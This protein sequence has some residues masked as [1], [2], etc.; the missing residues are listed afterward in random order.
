[1]SAKVLARIKT[2][3]SLLYDKIAR[4]VYMLLFLLLL[5]VNC[6]YRYRAYR[7]VHAPSWA[8][9]VSASDYQ[10]SSNLHEQVRASTEG[11]VPTTLLIN[12]EQ[13]WVFQVDHFNDGSN[14]KSGSIM[15][16]TD[17]AN[18]L[19]T[20][21]PSQNP[22][23]LKVNLMHEVFHA[24]GCLHGGDRYWNS[25]KPSDVDHPGIYHLGQFVAVF[26]HDNQQFAAWESQ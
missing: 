10:P 8:N 19:I 22:A 18:K 9:W 1:M 15:A 14:E 16:E 17:C 21:I 26:L 23:V 13:W 20:Y 6:Y 3:K 2:R 4:R 24:G 12:G 7:L 5:G 11:G 25:E